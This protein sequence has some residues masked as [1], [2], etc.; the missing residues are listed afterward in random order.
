MTGT[1]QIDMACSLKV[2]KLVKHERTTRNANTVDNEL[3]AMNVAV[4]LSA[5]IKNYGLSVTHV[6][7]L[8]SANT[9]DNGLHVTH[10][11]VLLSANM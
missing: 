7:V 5:N 8:L 2:V 3:N 9:V 11:A 1:T 6:A 4:L 10:V